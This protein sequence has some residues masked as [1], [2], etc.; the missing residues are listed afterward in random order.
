[1]P[2]LKLT[3]L[4]D[5]W[6]FFAYAN[7]HLGKDYMLHLWGFRN[8]RQLQRWASAPVHESSEPD[9]LS[10]ILT[11]MEELAARGHEQFVLDLLKRIVRRFGLE[12]KVPYEPDKETLDEEALDTA[13]ALGQFISELKQVQADGTISLDEARSLVARAEHFHQ[14]T[15]ELLTASWKLLRKIEKEGA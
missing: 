6:E 13:E 14:Q 15:G 9:P 1:M 4:P 10:K 3:K 12:L 7:H 11:M 2:R 8:A 5:T